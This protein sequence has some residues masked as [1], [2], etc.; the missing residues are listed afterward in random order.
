MKRFLEGET[1]R[2]ETEWF[3]DDEL[4]GFDARTGIAVDADCL[5]AA[6]S[7]IYAARF[8]SLRP[9]VHK[10]DTAPVFEVLLYEEMLLPP[11]APTNELDILR[12][13][14]PLGGEGK[15]AEVRVVTPVAWPEAG[16]STGADSS[17]W[18]LATPGI[19]GR[20][21]LGEQPSLP[22]DQPD[23]IKPPASLR[24][25]AS[26]HPIAVSGW[27]IAMNGPR[28]TSFAVPAGAVYYVEGD[29]TRPTQSLC[30]NEELAAEGWGSALRG[31]WNHD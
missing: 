22:V 18:V 20:P 11:G 17:L 2:R 13:P 24:A 19:F 16:P 9:S 4:F 8:L 1:P 27:D 5:T 28:P 3:R 26:M 25:A 6:K 21:E 10:K 31:V 15:Y 14:V 30:D 12:G 7:Q 29:F 23:A